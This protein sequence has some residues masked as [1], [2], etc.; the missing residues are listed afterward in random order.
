MSNGKANVVK[1]ESH[2][3]VA[4]SAISSRPW[5]WAEPSCPCFIARLNQFAA[6][7]R[8]KTIDIQEPV[9]WQD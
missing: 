7:F 6:K 8:S 4:F 5:A 3:L 2:F 1:G 9:G